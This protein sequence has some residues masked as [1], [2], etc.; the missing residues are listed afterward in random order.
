MSPIVSQ[1]FRTVFHISP[2]ESE[3]LNIQKYSRDLLDLKPFFKFYYWIDSLFGSFEG[4]KKAQLLIKLTG[5]RKKCVYFRRK[6]SEAFPPV[7]VLN[8]GNDLNNY[9]MCRH[10]VVSIILAF[11]FK[12]IVKLSFLDILLIGCRLRLVKY[13]LLPNRRVG[14]IKIRKGGGW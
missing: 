5:K 9:K 3:V 13:C 2:S 7:A 8:V 1:V 12:L 4:C 6:H 10:L 14:G 11:V